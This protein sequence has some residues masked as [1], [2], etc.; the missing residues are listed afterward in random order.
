M[1]FIL[2]LIL[3]FLSFLETITTLPLVL[4]VLLCF[5]V[6]FKKPWVFVL[7]FFMGL[8]LDL[9]QLRHLGQTSLFFIVFLIVVFMYDRRF[10]I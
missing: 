8:I 9:L 1:W 4:I 5:S 6:V 2:I 3:F 10:K 7:A